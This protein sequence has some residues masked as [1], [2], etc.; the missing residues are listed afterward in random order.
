[1]RRAPTAT[2]D[3][4]DQLSTIEHALSRKRAALRS[5]SLR[6]H[7]RAARTNGSGKVRFRIR[8]HTAARLADCADSHNLSLRAACFR[9]LS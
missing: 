3:Q 5:L 9:S 7:S 4:L 1:M 8:R 2:M 6:V